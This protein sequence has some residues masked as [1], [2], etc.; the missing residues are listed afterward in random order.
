MKAIKNTTSNS[1]FV[2]IFDVER[3]LGY[4]ISIDFHFLEDLNCLGQLNKDNS[5]YLCGSPK[6]N[7]DSLDLDGSYFLKFELSQTKFNMLIN[8]EYAHY[9][10]SLISYY[11][12]D[13]I[14]VGGKGSKKCEDY[15]IS[16]SKWKHLP[17]LPER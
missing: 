12:D 8:S 4:E 10:P 2:Q 3:E 1:T 7:K 11:F 15:S 13:I 17:D 14:I 16:C 5:L 6:V 9:S